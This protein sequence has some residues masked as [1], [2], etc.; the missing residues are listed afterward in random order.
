M[1]VIPGAYPLNVRQLL[2]IIRLTRRKIV[3]DQRA[4]LAN[5]AAND[6]DKNVLSAEQRL[7]SSC[8]LAQT[9]HPTYVQTLNWLLKDYGGRGGGGYLTQL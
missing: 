8:L 1:N 3:R 5:P 7:G 2:T 4:S 9:I 6:E